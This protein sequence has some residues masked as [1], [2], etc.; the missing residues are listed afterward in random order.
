MTKHPLE[1]R[2]AAPLWTRDD[3]P[4]A[5]ALLRFTDERFMDDVV[6]EL[7]SEPAAVAGRVTPA[8]ETWRTVASAATFTADDRAREPAK[9]YQPIHGRYYLAAAELV[10]QVA[11]LPDRKVNLGA[12]EKASM[13]LRRLVPRVTDASG[14]VSA[15]DEYAWRKSVTGG[16]W[17][18]AADP[19]SVL[20]GDGLVGREERLPAFPLPATV[21]ARP[22]TVFAAL[23]PASSRESFQAAPTTGLSPIGGTAAQLSGDP[24]ANPLLAE[25][26]ARVDGAFMLLRDRY[27]NEAVANGHPEAREALLFALVDLGELIEAN[28]PA[29]WARL[30]GRT[31][32][33]D[34]RGQDLWN[35]L[36]TPFHGATDYRAAIL[37]ARTLAPQITAGDVGGGATALTGGLS[38]AQIGA[39][40]GNYLGSVSAPARAALGALTTR[41]LTA[42]PVEVPKLDPGAGAYY[43]VRFVFEHGGCPPVV[44]APSRVFQLASYFDPDAPVR[45]VTVS[46]PV[47][48]SISGLRKFP[49]AVSFLVSNQLRQQME[50]VGK[51]KLKDL[52]DGAVGTAPAID[53]GM[54]CSFSIPIIT[55]CALILMMIIVSLLNIVFWWLPFL[56]IC[57]PIK[58]EAKS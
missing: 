39:S 43:A 29:V 36:A 27:V 5:P 55:I 3:V 48:T 50:R 2:T 21:E 19:A 22:R 20:D 58:L 1:W 38:K 32:T 11:G 49:K 51:V 10:C 26:E 12:G 37:A 41:P 8:L 14:R 46:L 28:L 34:T 4:R 31:S 35:A 53:L 52:D 23:V 18:L 57:L 56:K 33:L 13:V 44:S 24:L 54:I 30:E 15:W 40:V 25:L 6:R 7:V 47:D 45:R 17:A 9:L 42:E 16:S